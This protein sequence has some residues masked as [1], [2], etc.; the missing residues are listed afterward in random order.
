MLCEVSNPL[1]CKR[2]FYDAAM[3]RIELK[4][5]ETVRVELL[6]LTKSGLVVVA[7]ASE[8]E[9]RAV[10]A[11]TPPPAAQEA[12]LAGVKVA[13]IV[14][15]ADRVMIDYEHAMALCLEVSAGPTVFIVNDMIAKFQHYA[16]HAVTLH[17]DK[18]SGWVTQR[19]N[20]NYP[21]TRTVWAHRKFKDIVTNHTGDWGGSVGL[22]AVKIARELGFERILLCGVPMDPQS[23]HFVRHLRWN[24]AQAFW[25]AWVTRE[26]EI[27]PYVRSLSGGKTEAMFGAPD[28]AWLAH[29]ETKAA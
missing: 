25:R 6:N 16:E 21:P 11:P 18:L 24:A 3:Q 1:K 28:A 10:Y 5:G 14:G 27:K 29:N 17:P 22:F 23:N 15:G 7:I 19:K 9:R 8:T 4:A 12:R 2:I 26:K 13:V 20:N